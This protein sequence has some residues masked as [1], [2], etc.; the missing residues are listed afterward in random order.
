MA[1]DFI[2]ETNIT[3]DFIQNMGR[4]H[5]RFIII[6]YKTNDERIYLCSGSSKDGGNK[7]DVIL[8]SE[9]ELLDHTKI[10]NVLLNPK[11]V[12]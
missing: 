10:D 2:K 7:I 12:L 8:Q 6:D 4:F 5:A 3:I 9:T 11:L 1:N